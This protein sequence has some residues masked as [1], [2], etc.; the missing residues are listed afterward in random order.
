VEIFF[1][2]MGSE[3]GEV[4]A[5]KGLMQGEQARKREMAS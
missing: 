1:I 3:Q 5:L 2:Q 4:F